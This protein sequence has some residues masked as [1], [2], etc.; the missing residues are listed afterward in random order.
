M[1]ILYVA[2]GSALGGVV[3]Y[4][5]ISEVSRVFGDAFPWGTLAVNI[6]GSF[7]LGLII[8]VIPAQFLISPAHTFAVFG[9]C[10]GLTTFSNFSLQNLILAS[11]RRWQAVAW[12]IIGSVSLCMICAL[13]GYLIGEESLF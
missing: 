4:L 7:F 1:L 10:G 13:A 6:T 9:F 2:L 3:R 8:G 11:R 5:I 12:N